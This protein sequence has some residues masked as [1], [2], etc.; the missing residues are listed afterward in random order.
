M[1]MLSG[2]TVRAAT[3]RCGQLRVECIGEP[4]RI[5]VC[6][7][8][9][10]QKRS[11]SAFAVQAR[12]PDEK[13]TLT[14]DYHTWQRIT[15]SDHC[16]TYRFCPICGSTL[17]Y[18]IEGWEGVTAVPVGAFADINFPRPSFSVYENRKHDWVEIKGE[19]VKHSS[20]PSSICKPN[21]KL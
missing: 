4:I 13:I 19:K 7:C 20:T 10:C 8:L 17:T 14:G 3:C 5:S 16:A 21:L 18:I 2:E 12:W 1:T 15:D 11:G 6:H 9:A